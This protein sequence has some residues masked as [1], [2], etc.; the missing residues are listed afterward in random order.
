[1]YSKTMEERID[2]AETILQPL[3]AHLYTVVPVAMS[4]QTQ[5]EMDVSL[6][7][8]QASLKVLLFCPGR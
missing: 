5:E 3:P 7:Y 8:Q 1:M 6:D 2:H 4:N